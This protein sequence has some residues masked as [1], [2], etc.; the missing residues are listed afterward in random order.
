M[1]VIKDIYFKKVRQLAWVT[2]HRWQ[3]YER[4]TETMYDLKPLL[5]LFAAYFSAL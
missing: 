1:I 5:P 4:K 3:S 2:S